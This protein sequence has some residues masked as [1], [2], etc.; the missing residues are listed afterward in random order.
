MEGS[1]RTRQKRRIRDCGVIRIYWTLLKR[2]T[3]TISMHW[4]ADMCFI[5]WHRWLL[6]LSNPS[7]SPS[8]LAHWGFPINIL[9]GRSI[10]R[11][12][13]LKYFPIV[14]SDRSVSGQPLESAPLKH[15]YHL[16]TILREAQLPNDSE[17]ALSGLKCRDGR[18]PSH[19]EEPPCP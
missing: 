18:K 15:I 17:T 6:K 11:H 5:R 9:T 1:V 7:G 8:I 13:R 12:V 19:L 2:G 4:S 16:G 3:C 10:H 14:H